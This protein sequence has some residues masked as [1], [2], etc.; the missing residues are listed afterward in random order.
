MSEPVSEELKAAIEGLYDTFSSYPFSSTMEGCPCCVS[1]GD[2]SAL[3]SKSLR[4]LTEEDIQ[5][6]AYKAMTT[7]G[8]VED[9]KHYLPRIFELAST[10]EFIV[11]TFVVLGKLDYAHWKSWPR[12]EVTAIEKFLL[13]WWADAVRCKSYYDKEL[14]IEI[15]SRIG[16]SGVLLNRW[17]LSFS[18]NSF[19][20]FVELVE[21]FHSIIH[22]HF[23]YKKMD[24]ASVEQIIR[25][26]TDKKSILEE[27]FF[28]FEAKEP[29]LAQRISNA[30]YLLEHISVDK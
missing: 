30:L 21:D 7:W 16:S 24:E 12:D 10:T 17:E 3:H 20:N 18:N 25:W 26:V 23:G 1:E 22:R 11:D 19:K 27:G 29:E 8:E 6:Y 14:L 28:V 9:F 2:K 5:R 4:E 13:A 15:G